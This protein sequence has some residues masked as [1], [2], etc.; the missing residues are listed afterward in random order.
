MNNT[1][2][3]LMFGLLAAILPLQLSVASAETTAGSKIGELQC[4]TIPGSGTNLFL[5]STVEVKCKFSSSTAGETEHYKGE[6]G[7][8]L[9][10]DLSYKKESS[11][12]FVVMA[13]DFKKGSYKL[14][15]KYFGAGADVTIGRGLGA[16]VLIGGSKKSVALQPIGISF[17]KGIGVSGGLTYLYL[18]PDKAKD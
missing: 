12:A 11:F 10:V 4:K 8:A 6:T 2:R 13:A 18:E 14:A 16:G 3:I 7:I 15:G 9:G 17:T 5:H 1:L